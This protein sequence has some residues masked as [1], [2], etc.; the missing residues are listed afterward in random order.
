MPAG[1]TSNFFFEFEKGK[2]TV[3]HLAD[4][5]EAWTYNMNRMD[6]NS[7]ADFASSIQIK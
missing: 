3:K 6:V 2:V 5:S 7:T 1:F 4:S